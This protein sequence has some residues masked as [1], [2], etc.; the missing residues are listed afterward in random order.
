V[1]SVRV[2]W[3]EAYV[4][5]PDATSRAYREAGLWGTR[6]IA[7]ELRAAAAQHP[8]RPAVRA[9]DGR[10]TYA[11]L[12]RR[13]D[14]VAA[15]LH[16]R[17]VAPGDRVLFQVGNGLGTVLAWYGALKA[18]LIPVCTLAQHRRHEIDAIARLTEARAHVVQADLP[19]FDLVAFGR[20]VA[21][22]CPSLELLVTVGGAGDEPAI[23]ALG[24]DVGDAEARVLVDAI[25]ATIDPDEI[26]VFQLSGGT[27]STPKIIPRL[28][29]E[30]WYNARAYAQFWGWG[31]QARPAHVIPVIH[32]AGITCALHAAH[33]VGACLIVGPPDAEALAPVFEEERAT[34]VILN[35]TLATMVIG[36][37]RLHAAVRASVERIVFSGSKLPQH[38]IDA[39]ESEPTRIVQLFGMGE[40]LFLVTP[41]DATHEIRHTSVGVPLSPLDEVRILDPAGEDELPLGAEGE[42]CCRG[43]YTIRGYYAAAERNRDAFTSDGFYRT[44][45]LAIA[46]EIDGSICYLIEGRLK[47]VI[48][49]GGEKVNA[50]EIELVLADHPA[51]A[52][53]A[54][55]AMPDPRLGERACAYVVAA[56][57]AE[58]LTLPA[59]TAYLDAR[60]VAKFKW[61]ERIEAIDALP[62]TNIGKIDK[63]A[64]RED[65]A[66]RLLAEVG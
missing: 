64:L 19:T 46:A 8:Q 44:G 25:Q 7:Q 61:P 35:L 39:F 41:A 15:G 17:G 38:V 4:P 65:I 58:H 36:H 13:T 45:D 29:A 10:L 52:A 11:E 18:G 27:T 23:E 53:V 22:D 24:E 40:G 59:I 33:A 34:D 9:L 63:Q 31:P 2:N 56:D 49:R 43:P 37:R 12:D 51:V 26:A 1:A 16:A 54:V 55:V 20:E 50:E 3:G 28:H 21:R 47:D 57:G 60:G 66:S 32:N 42:L 14:R 62:T 30:Y 6:T 48:A 5:Y